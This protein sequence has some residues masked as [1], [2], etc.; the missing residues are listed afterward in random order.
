MVTKFLMFLLFLM[1]AGALALEN[2]RVLVFVLVLPVLSSFLFHD[3]ACETCRQIALTVG[4]IG[5]KH[6]APQLPLE[7]LGTLFRQ[8]L[9]GHTRIFFK[10]RGG[11]GCLLLCGKSYTYLQKE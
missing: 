11:K 1:F 9:R 10:G 4:V 8:N 7:L 2:A 6:A 5:L 3:P